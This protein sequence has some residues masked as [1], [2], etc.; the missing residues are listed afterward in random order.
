MREAT[1]WVDLIPMERTLPGLDDGLFRDTCL[2]ETPGH[3]SSD[4]GSVISWKHEENSR[5][6]SIILITVPRIYTPLT[7]VAQSR[8]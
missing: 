6:T 8:P 3:R 7:G 1:R 2:M 4:N 5:K